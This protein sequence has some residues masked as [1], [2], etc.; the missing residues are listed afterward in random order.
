ML[1]IARNSC[2]Q[3]WK[4]HSLTSDRRLDYLCATRYACGTGV[5]KVRTAV[6]LMF[7]SFR[8]TCLPKV[9]WTRA[10]HALHR[11]SFSVHL[12]RGIVSPRVCQTDLCLS[13]V[14]SDF[15]RWFASS[16]EAC[17]STLVCVAT[18]CAERMSCALHVWSCRCAGSLYPCCV[19]PGA[20]FLPGTVCE[21]ENVFH[22]HNCAKS[23]VGQAMFCYVPVQFLSHVR[24]N[25][26]IQRCGVTYTLP[27]LFCC[28]RLLLCVFCLCIFALWCY[29]L[30]LA[31][32]GGPGCNW[33]HFGEGQEGLDVSRRGRHPSYANQIW[34]CRDQ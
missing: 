14:F 34:E 3:C 9:G 19:L 18:W 22:V 29:L 12:F 13:R 8:N 10:T 20:V 7:A 15:V 2:R 21:T 4:T 33:L 27:F 28:D 17:S 11:S 26:C 30:L 32:V 24:D 1:A 16:R 5:L 6:C 31:F 25:L 23:L